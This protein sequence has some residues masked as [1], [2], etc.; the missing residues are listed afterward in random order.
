AARENL[1]R[2][3]QR[4]QHRRARARETILYDLHQGVKVVEAQVHRQVEMV[5]S[6]L[7]GAPA[8]KYAFALTNSF[9]AQLP[10]TCTGS[11]LAQAVA[12]GLFQTDPS[13]CPQQQQQQEQQESSCRNETESLSNDFSSI[14]LAGQLGSER[15]SALASLGDPNGLST[16]MPPGVAA[17]CTELL[18]AAL[19]SFIPSMVAPLVCVFS[20][21]TPPISD[22][23]PITYTPYPRSDVISSS[24]SSGTAASS[25]STKE[26]E[27]PPGRKEFVYPWGHPNEALPLP[28]SQPPLQP[29]TP[30]QSFSSFSLS[31]SSSSSAEKSR[32][33][34]HP[35]GAP[36]PGIVVVHSK[37]WTQDEREALYLAAT[38]FR[39]SG[40]WSKI[41]EMMNLHRTDKEIETEYMKLYGHRDNDD[42]GDDDE[43]DD[44]HHEGKGGGV[45]QFSNA[46]SDADA[47]D[48]TDVIFMKFGGGGSAQHKRLQL[49]HLQSRQLH[50]DQ[51][52]YQAH[53]PIPQ[54]ELQHHH[55]HQY[56]QQYQ[57]SNDAHSH[58]Q[59]PPLHDHHHHPHQQ[60][61]DPRQRFSAEEDHI[62]IFKKEFMIDKR[63]T[64]EEIPMR[65]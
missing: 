56:H 45:G 6:R 13:S 14:A 16:M 60:I 36:D 52:H 46:G 3:H 51:L 44:D 53:A 50:Y 7:K 28:V 26:V 22:L 40:Q 37:T 35:I 61:Y 18:S 1:D 5:M 43:D 64:L 42:D 55:H 24:S 8:S 31:P 32:E 65:I 25:S 23:A 15:P 20:Y 29:I 34:S 58:V 19:P 17:A 39:L 9:L 62:R 12:S 41:R 54:Q 59:H 11:I 47:D 57:H 63:F 2:L 33:Q 48:E 30:T 21:Q 10:H 38:R 27:E 4:I 49:Q